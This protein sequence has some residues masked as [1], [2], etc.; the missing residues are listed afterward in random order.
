MPYT[1]EKKYF[2]KTEFLTNNLPVY[3]LLFSTKS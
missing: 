2:N 1:G 3:R